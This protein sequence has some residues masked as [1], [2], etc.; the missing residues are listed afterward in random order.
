[1]QRSN[2]MIVEFNQVST[3]SIIIIFKSCMMKNVKHE[4]PIQKESIK[5]NNFEQ[6]QFQQVGKIVMFKVN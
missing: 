6:T 4:M 5:N 2:E 3:N 1:M